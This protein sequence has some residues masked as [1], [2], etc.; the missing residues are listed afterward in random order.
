MLLSWDCIIKNEK[1][2]CCRL[3][4]FSSGSNE[5]SSIAPKFKWLDNAFN[6]LCS[7]N[8]GES[9]EGGG[10]DH[11][12][13]SRTASITFFFQL[14]VRW[15]CQGNRESF[16]ARRCF[17]TAENTEYIF[18]CKRAIL[19]FQ[20]IDPPPPLRPESVYPPPPRLCCGGRTDSPGGEGDGGG[21][22]ILE[23]E[24]NRIA[25]LQYIKYV[26]CGWEYGVTLRTMHCRLCISC[27]TSG[28]SEAKSK[29]PAWGIKSTLAQGCP[30]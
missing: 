4:V 18:Y 10:D 14:G 13:W 5:L 11:G 1:K 7:E 26:L 19:F 3:P 12:L 21:V 29:V 27:Y 9:G 16:I 23:D 8:K 15:G 17:V 6:V 24:R 22:N 2:T 30:W 28:Q 25:L 20:N